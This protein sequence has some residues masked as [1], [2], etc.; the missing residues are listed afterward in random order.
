MTSVVLD[1]DD[2]DEQ[3]A[4]R[5]SVRAFA[6]R[7]LAP[8][9]DE[10]EATGKYPRELLKKAADQGLIGLTLA[11][12]LGGLGAGVRYQAI[13]TEE[14][15][16]VCAGLATGLNGLGLNLFKYASQEQRDRYL[17]PTLAGECTGSFAIT[18]PDAGS[19][20]L[21]MSGRAVRTADGWRITANKMYITKAPFAEY[22]FVVV[23]T[24]KE[25]RRNGLSAFL[26]DTSTPGVTVEKMDKLGHWSMETG[27]V[28]L[29]CELPAEALLGE[30]G[31]GLEYVGETLELGRVNHASRSLGVARAAYDAAVAYAHDRSTFGRPI[32][33]H[34][35]IQFKLAR[36]LTTVRSAAL[37]VRDAAVR[38]EQGQT[39][40]GATN[41]AKLVASEAAVSVATDAMQV[42]GGM[43]YIM[44][45]P[46]QRFLRDAFL[47]PV[48]EGTSEIQLRN[49]ARLT[50]IVST[51]GCGH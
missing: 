37:H 4:F 21:N 14:L 11:E 44:E 7:E 36:M 5:S 32:N 46:V 35:A 22:L 3:R 50:G 33:Q 27:M 18:E 8:R 40:T 20:V 48:S 29:D 15:A 10:A 34:Q 43:S 17:V 1:L 45:T 38:V 24:D 2:T 12:E 47:Y 30:E 6:K 28:Y 9:S 13:A 51:T 42:F 41:M 25:A 31:R 26:V 19:D 23:Y 49:I 39:T 16:Y